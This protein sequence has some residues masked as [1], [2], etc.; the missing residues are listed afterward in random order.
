MFD[1]IGGVITSIVDVAA[2]GP[3]KRERA[4]RAAASAQQATA[5]AMRTQALADLQIAQIEA[6]A[7]AART[8]GITQ[9]ILVGGG[10]GLAGLT[11]YLLLK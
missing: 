5:D 4:A 9:L 7:S 8:E 6:D 10:V 11:L 3:Q 1:A 2:G